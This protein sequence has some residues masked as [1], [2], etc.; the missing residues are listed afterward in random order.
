MGLIPRKKAKKKTKHKCKKRKFGFFKIFNWRNISIS[1][2]YLGSFSIVAIL[3]I[4][5]GFI[6][7]TQ[8]NA[9]KQD[10][11]QFED[12][13]IRSHDVAKMESLLQE[14]DLRIED[15]IITR[16]EERRVGK[17][18]KSRLTAGRHIQTKV[19]MAIQ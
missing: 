9:A 4:I 6:V 13:V 3:F 5:S 12:D 19:I 10:I 2:K 11:H 8:L 14:K 17:D 7:Y 1:Q 15:Y 18:N 16:S